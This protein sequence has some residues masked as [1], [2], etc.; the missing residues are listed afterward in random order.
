MPD[1]THLTLFLA[2]AFI[3]AITPGPGLFYVLARSLRGGRA[4]GL[5]STAGTAIGGM[6]HVV[7]AAFGLSALLATSTTAF[8]LVKYAGAAYLIFL[9]IQTLLRREKPLHAAPDI[10]SPTTPA[11]ATPDQRIIHSR[12]SRQALRQGI[13]TELLN[14][15]TALFFLA[16]IPH[17]VDPT[18]PLI[19]QFCL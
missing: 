7:A 9:G 10:S 12:R 15:K 14:P 6:G 18:H 16:F 5:A 13:I 11:N 4:E 2:A 19:P 1:F 17:F 3:L 8:A